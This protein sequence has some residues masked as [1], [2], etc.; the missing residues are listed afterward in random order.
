MR[1]DPAGAGDN[2][3]VLRW[4][5][6]L[7]VTGW[8]QIACMASMPL[9]FIAVL[10]GW[11]VTEAGRQPFVVYGQLRTADAVAPVATGA[12]LSSLLAFVVVYNILLL[13]FFWYGA[14]TVLRG[15]EGPPR[16]MRPIT[17]DPG[18]IGPAPQ[19]SAPRRRCMPQRRESDDDLPL[20]FALVTAFAIVLYVLADGFD[21]GVGILFLL[22][23][24]DEDRDLMMES[25]SPLW[26]GNETWLVFGGTLL[27]AAFP[28]GYSVLLPAFY[29]PIMGC[30]S[31]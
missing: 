4:K 9:G 23:P 10:A 28:I 16:P 14:R 26:D 24:R 29:L 13:A 6:R 2:G 31:R 25:L 20:C 19:S 22:A 30:C 11:T 12:V 5:R 18:W 8:F 21:L 27:L 17:F 7:Y 3:A 1:V 15:P